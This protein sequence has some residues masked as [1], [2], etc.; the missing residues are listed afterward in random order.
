MEDN[1]KMDLQDMG[2]IAPRNGWVWLKV[3]ING[4]FLSTRYERSGFIECGESLT[5]QQISGF[6]SRTLLRG[7]LFFH[8]SAV[9]STQFIGWDLS[10][11]YFGMF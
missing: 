7:V 9:F 8:R 1:I 5:S 6:S 10:E 3:Y 11:I 4:G 2:R